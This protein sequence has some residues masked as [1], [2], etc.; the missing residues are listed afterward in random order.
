MELARFAGDSP[1]G[2]ILD[3]LERDGGVIVEGFAKPDLVDALEAD[4]RRA[5]DAVPWG[6]TAGDMPPNSFF[7]RRTKRLHGLLEKSKSFGDAISA[8]LAVS[9][10]GRFLEPNARD[11][12]V[13]TGELMAIGAGEKRQAL[14]RDADSW[15]RFPDP[16]P[17][18]LVSVNLALTDFSEANGAT[19]VLPGSHA[20]ES[21]RRPTPEDAVAFA[22]M[23][24]GSALLYTGNV[25][26][27][28]GANETDST[29]IG[30]YWGYLLS[31]LQPLENHLIT[32]GQAALEG[33]SETAQ[34]LLGYDRIGWRVE[35]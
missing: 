31:W 23:P 27:G 24:R 19:V 14:H 22:E 6:N 15:H 32:N 5:L 33:A 28:G 3:G 2:P 13:S 7:G 30:L 34:R 1:P 11:Y 10:C 18:I 20:W 29:R 26:H 21:K 16:R 12:R 9:M 17:E 25:W 4:Y 35:P 8:D